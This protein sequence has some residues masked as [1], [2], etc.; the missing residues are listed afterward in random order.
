VGLCVGTSSTSDGI[1]MFVTEPPAAWHGQ[2][3]RETHASLPGA[4]PRRLLV[5]RLS[6]PIRSIL[7]VCIGVIRP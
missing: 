5:S 3:G 2:A 4:L 6:Y 7:A 1:P